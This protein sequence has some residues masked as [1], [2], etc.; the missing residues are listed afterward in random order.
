[1]LGLAEGA[2]RATGAKPNTG[3]RRGPGQAALKGRFRHML[4]RAEDM[5]E[6]QAFLG[7]TGT[8]SDFEL[9]W[10][11]AQM[12]ESYDLCR[13][14][15]NGMMLLDVL[16]ALFLTHVG[17]VATVRKQ[18]ASLRS[19]P[20]PHHR[21]RWPTSPECALCPQNQGNFEN[22]SDLEWMQSM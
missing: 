21:N 1:M 20:C 8:E 13:Q 10:V 3:R 16:L 15:G 2:R 22:L 14:D 12:I 19:D 7:P 4:L 9:G 11:A 6:R 5:L 17:Q 18:P